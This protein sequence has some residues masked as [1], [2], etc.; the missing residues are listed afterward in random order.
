VGEENEG[1]IIRMKKGIDA[2]I[3]ARILASS[4][5]S[6]DG[7][8]EEEDE[9]TIII[10]KEGRSNMKGCFFT[11]TKENE[12]KSI[13]LIAAEGTIFLSSLLHSFI[14]ATSIVLPSF[15]FF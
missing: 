2:R 11:K 15:S 8:G 12:R 14:P 10:M 6:M 5:A 3:D 9:G 1:T 7:V 4:R 13:Q